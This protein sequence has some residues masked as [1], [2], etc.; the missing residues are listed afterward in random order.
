MLIS[1][2]QLIV[3]LLIGLL[4]GSLAG[5]LLSRHSQNAGV[6]MAIGLLGGVLG[7]LIFSALNI[8]IGGDITFA[9]HDLVAALIGALILLV[10]FGILRR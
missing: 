10:L 6:S 4:A 5:Q 2:G 9:I 7:G 8:R 1:V 3:W